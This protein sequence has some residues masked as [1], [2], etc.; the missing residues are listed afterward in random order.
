MLTVAVTARG[1]AGEA[2]LGT[3]DQFVVLV[4]AAVEVILQHAHIH[5]QEGHGRAGRAISNPKSIPLPSRFL[6]SGIY[7]GEPLEKHTNACV[8]GSLEKHGV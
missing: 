5:C 1:H 2:T 4:A 6:F 8:H 7:P 3:V